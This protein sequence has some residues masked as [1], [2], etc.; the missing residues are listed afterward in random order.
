MAM[1]LRV[2]DRLQRGSELPHLK[3]R[4]TMVLDVN[5]V[6]EH[7]P[8]TATAPTDAA[9]LAIWK[10][11]EAKAKSLILDGIKD[12]VIPH[13]SG[14]NT[15]KDM[16]KSLSDLYQP[17]NENK[18]MVLRERLR[19]SKMAKGEGVVPY[20]T[21]LTQIRDELAAVGEKTEDV[22]LV[23][24]A[25]NGF[26][27]SWDVFVH[28]VVAREKL[29]EWQ[30]LW[31]DF[32]QEEIR[33]GQSSGSSSS[34]HIV[35]EEG[36]ALASKGKGKKKKGGKKKNID[37]SKVKCFQCHKMGHFASQCPEKKKKDKPQMAASA[38]VDEF[39][40]SF[41]EDFC[42]VA[43]MSS[44]AVSD[45]WFVDSGA[46]CHMTG[47]KEFF[48]RLQEG[49]VNLVIELGDD[50][51]YKAQGVGT[52]TFQRESGKPLWF[53]DVLYVPG[54]TKNLIS[55]S[56][57]EDKGYEVTFRNGKVFVRPA[58]SGTKMDRII[59][60]RQREFTD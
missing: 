39:A 58:G 9:Q 51:R 56:T 41:E 21:R 8:E 2:E 57:L 34:P 28:G 24:V 46:S 6:L 14:K 29:P 55:V 32:V 10:K 47:R 59:G 43:C 12:H 26:S 40:K 16:W 22:E 7:T 44:T 49:G 27:K 1:S 31:D 35:D 42:F 15:A 36:L 37:F 53:A 54:L 11:G 52:V 13:L 5:D 45:I 23:R 38:A 19:S 20:L 17:K 3:E 60:V 50:R 33:L 25:L 30:H 48:T 18:V 4:M